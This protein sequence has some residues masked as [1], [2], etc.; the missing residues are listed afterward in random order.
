MVRWSGEH[1]VNVKSQSE[2]D[3]GGRETC[4]NVTFSQ[5]DAQELKDSISFTKEENNFIMSFCMAKANSW[6]ALANTVAMPLTY[7]FA[8]NFGHALN[9]RLQLFSRPRIFRAGFIG[10]ISCAY[11]VL[12]ISWYNYGNLEFDSSIYK[13]ICKTKEQ[14]DS[15]ISYYDKLLRRNVILRRVIGKEMDYY[16]QES[17]EYV[18]MIYQLP[19]ACD[20]S[21]KI[22]LLNFMKKAKEEEL[23]ELKEE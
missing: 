14:I 5:E 3:I 22:K 7:F 19:D 10:W 4:N 18:P 21:A 11:L 20:I 2:L 6:L 16:I 1:Q 13:D 15:G 8:Y 17:G 12:Y 9:K 23:E